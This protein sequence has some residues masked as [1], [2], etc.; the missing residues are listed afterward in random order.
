MHD[1]KRSRLAAIRPKGSSRQKSYL[2]VVMDDEF[3]NSEAIN[4]LMRCL[5]A[6]C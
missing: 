5:S 3:T 4:L 2:D 1:L 6:P